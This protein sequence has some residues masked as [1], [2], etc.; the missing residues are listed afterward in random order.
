MTPSRSRSRSSQKRNVSIDSSQKARGKIFAE[1]LKFRPTPEELIHWMSDP[2][3]IDKRLAGTPLAPLINPGGYAAPQR[4]GVL[5]ELNMVAGS[6]AAS[7][8]AGGY[9][10]DLE[11]RGIG[12]V[13]ARDGYSYRA[14]RK[15]TQ[16]CCLS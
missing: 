1:L 2:E 8:Q 6:F 15:R 7:P 11:R 4:S 16:S 3:E 13:S 14:R 5:S 9:E 10:G 12:P